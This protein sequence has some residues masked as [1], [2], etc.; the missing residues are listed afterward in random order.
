MDYFE[1]YQ[2][3]AENLGYEYG[4][5]AK[6]HHFWLFAGDPMLNRKFCYLKKGN[7][8]FWAHDMYG[9]KFGMNKTYSGVYCFLNLPKPSFECRIAKR[10]ILDFIVGEKRDKLGKA[11]IDKSVS[12]T[13]NDKEFARKIVTEELVKNYLNLPDG[14]APV[15]VVFGG[16]YLPKLQGHETEQT[17]GL[18]TNR[19]YTAEELEKYLPVM[20]KFLGSITVPV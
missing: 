5:Y 17:V 2:Q 8:F 19:W 1:P 15:E 3:L 20:E 12:V 11:F 9:T 6:T 18:E 7:L 10:F 4:D 13:T 16:E 14:I